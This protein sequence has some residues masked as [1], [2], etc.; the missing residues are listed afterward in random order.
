MWFLRFCIEVVRELRRVDEYDRT[1]PYT[2][3]ELGWRDTELR[4]KR[5]WN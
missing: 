1:T 3:T 5:R 4:A 2:L